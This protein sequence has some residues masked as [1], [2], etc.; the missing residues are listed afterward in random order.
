LTVD[1]E[2]FFGASRPAVE[3]T[4]LPA[5]AAGGLRAQL[6]AAHPEAV[7]RVVRGRKATTVPAFFDEAAAAL[8]LPD[9]F[10]EN[11][12]SFLS[13]LRGLADDSTAPHAMVISDAVLLLSQAD[14][15]EFGTLVAVLGAVDAEWQAKHP[16]RRLRVLLG[17]TGARLDELEARLALARSNA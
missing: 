16:P 9:Y 12:D 11:W 1:L 4:A 13:S 5:F 15:A 2:G 17:E 10:S 14:P 7:V 8:Q 3:S 6:S